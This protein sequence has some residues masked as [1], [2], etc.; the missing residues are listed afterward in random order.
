MWTKCGMIKQAAEEATKAKD[1]KALEELKGKATRPGEATEIDRMIAGLK[2][3]LNWML[4]ANKH[5][6]MAHYTRLS[7]RR[8]CALSRL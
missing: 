1:L 7:S 3:Q 8:I 5:K 2:R 6:I 4:D